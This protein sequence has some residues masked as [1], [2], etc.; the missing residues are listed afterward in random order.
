MSSLHNPDLSTPL[1]HLLKLDKPVKKP[2]IKINDIFITDRKDILSDTSNLKKKKKVK[3]P[4]D[5]FEKSRKK[6]TKKY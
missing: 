1:L 5:T 4:I 3:L 2:K 6:I